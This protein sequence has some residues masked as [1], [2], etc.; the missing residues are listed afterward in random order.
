MN[1]QS[2][3]IGVSKSIM[4]TVRST[5]TSDG[6]RVEARQDVQDSPVF[7]YSFGTFLTISSL[8]FGGLFFYLF[9][10]A[11]YTFIWVIA[12]LIGLMLIRSGNEATK[13]AKTY[14]PPALYII[15]TQLPLRLSQRFRVRYQQPVMRD[16]RLISISATL[17]CQEWVHSVRGRGQ[18]RTIETS[19]VWK[20]Q[21]PTQTVIPIVN[22]EL[23]V[24]WDAEVPLSQ[25]ASFVA[26]HNKVEWYLRVVL[27]AE[28]MPVS[29]V[30][31]PLIVR[32]EVMQ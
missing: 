29:N 21:L 5:K 6:V 30:V 26:E 22:N 18:G 23:S 3:G 28:S 9:G 2:G 1:Q 10:P 24:E 27:Q 15:E 20:G 13:L 12:A 16:V 7:L 25:P 17:L 31:F 14:G 32:L 19:V 4:P 8:V 11:W